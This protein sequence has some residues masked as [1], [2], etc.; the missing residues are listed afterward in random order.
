M[1]DPKIYK[2]IMC[3]KRFTDGKFLRST[4]L[5]H[6]LVLHQANMISMPLESLVEDT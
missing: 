5:N 1:T 3:E 2:C 4:V 6:Y